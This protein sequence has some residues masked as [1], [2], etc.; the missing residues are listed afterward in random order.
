MSARTGTAW[1]PQDEFILRELYAN[2]SNQELAE[3]LDRAPRYVGMKARK[4][5][6][7]KSEAF[8]AKQGGRFQKGHSTWN[9]GKPRSTGTHP[10]CKRTQFKPGEMR[11]AAQHNY[12]PVGSLRVTKDG[13]LER[14]TNDDHPVPARRWVSVHR[15]VW[16]AANGPVP[17]GHVVVF[18]PGMRTAVEDEVTLDRLELVSRA[19]LMR[20]N[21]VHR[22]P[23]EL[24]RLIQLRGALNRQI[25]KRAQA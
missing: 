13:Y 22:Y 17:K 7:K 2:T 24:A 4:L 8:L 5:G 6:L 23:K 19:D 3:L 1:S 18:K 20:R 14:K 11:G 10:N 25:N 16:E 12:V 21:T 9:A 15:L